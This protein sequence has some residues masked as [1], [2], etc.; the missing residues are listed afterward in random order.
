MSQTRPPIFRESAMKRY[1]QRQEKDILPRFVSPRIFAYLWILLILMMLGGLLSWWTEIPTFASG[2][3][4]ILT[5][6]QSS[7]PGNSK[8][9]VLLFLPATYA[10]QVHV[11]QPVQMQIDSTGPRFLSAIG[12]VKSGIIS[13]DDARQQ[14]ALGVVTSQALTQPSIVVIVRPIKA[15]TT[16]RYTGS[17][18]SAQVQI[19]SYRVLSLLPG[20]D[21]LIGDE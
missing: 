19:G 6:K 18:V 20:F 21:R 3:G 12:Q 2:S 16:S 7:I 15:L 9:V 11:G 4:I 13:P 14:Y 10:S 5:Q 17:L 8:E 1:M